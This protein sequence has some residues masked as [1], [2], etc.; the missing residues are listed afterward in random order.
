M[1]PEQLNL[2][3]SNPNKVFHQMDTL[4]QVLNAMI[5]G[6]ASSLYQRSRQKHVSQL[7]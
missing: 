1:K 5:F 7:M 6:M 3:Q 4:V 2:P